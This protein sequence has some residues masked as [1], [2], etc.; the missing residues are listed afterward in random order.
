LSAVVLV[1][2]SVLSLSGC[3]GGTPT[4]K[5]NKNFFTSGSPEADQR[6]SQRMA[7]SEQLS[8]S[9]E[10]SGEKG[11]KKAKITKPKEEDASAG[12]TNKPAQA[13]DKQSLFVR[14]GGQAGVSNIVAD[15]TARVLDDPRV[16]WER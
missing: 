7:Q 12:S 13:E 8:G 11:V 3:G 16:N 5:A 15:F 14:L 1:G 9:G 10:G 2:T 6:A 4:Q